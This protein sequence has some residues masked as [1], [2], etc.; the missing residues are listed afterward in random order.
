MHSPTGRYVI[1]FNGEIYNFNSLRKKLETSGHPQDW[2]GSSDTEVLL[3]A[4]ECWGL[5]TALTEARGMFALAL[6][7]REA[8]CLSLARDGIGEKPLYLSRLR[9]GGLAFASELK[10]L[11]AHNGFDRTTDPQAISQLL[12]VGYIP[13]PKSLYCGTEKLRPGQIVNFSASAENAYSAST[14]NFFDLVDLAKTAKA[15]RFAGNIEEATDKL[16]ALL[17][18]SVSRQMVADV[19]V[20]C[21]L[22]GGIDSS[23]IAAVMQSLGSAPVKTFSLGFREP[24]RN[25][26]DFAR[27]IA[28]HLQVDHN[29]VILSGE[30]AL[31]ILPRMV[32]VYDEPFC[33]DSMLPTFLLSEF[34]KQKVTVCLSGDGGDEL[35][36]G[37]ERYFSFLT[38]W[39]TKARGTL[40]G[41]TGGGADAYIANHLLPIL[42]NAG[43]PT[44]AAS[45]LAAK[46]LSADQR[47]AGRT[48]L[49]PLAANEVSRA[50]VARS[51][52][53]VLGANEQN[54]PLVDALDKCN[55]W[56]LLDKMTVYDL[57]RYFPDDILVKVDRAAMTNSL[58]TRLPLL[59]QEILDFS[60]RLPDKIR[61]AGDTP[62][63][64]LRRVL[65]RYIPDDL[66]QRPKKGFG[67]PVES[68]LRG[69]MRDMADDLLSPA[70]LKNVGV[71]DPIAVD[72][73]WQRFRNGRSKRSNLVWSLLMTQIFLE[74]K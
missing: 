54:D 10:S 56:S 41:K 14:D 9:D 63:G 38:S 20:G 60:L 4:I 36:A 13:A 22:S 52:R 51:D 30:Q 5:K 42:L 59:D 58:E 43:L 67:I 21:F 72:S 46:Q 19:P 11:M 23:T 6:W 57:M 37:Y 64:L 49:P 73:L 15:N 39:G 45:K 29:E 25:E 47:V 7:D 26:A 65:R 68:W 16:D 1:A 69:P 71:L 66:W 61:L 12:R 31:E 70:S 2:R 34:T 48:I 24:E 8:R 74:H 35:F 17:R 40:S 3:A 27:A 50:S 53:F 18:S 32:S 44:F 62:K 33:D 55:D 28:N